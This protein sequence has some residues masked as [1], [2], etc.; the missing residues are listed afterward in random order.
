LSSPLLP[1]AL[2]RP[3]STDHP[4]GWPRGA[5]ADRRI[6]RVERAEIAAQRAGDDR[7][8]SGHRSRFP[9]HTTAR[10]PSRPR[11]AA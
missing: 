2:S 3:L 1:R 10:A 9:F 11:W 4:E 8:L 5:T 6:D 7:G